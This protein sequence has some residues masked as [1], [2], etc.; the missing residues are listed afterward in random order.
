MPLQDS[1]TQGQFCWVDLLAHDQ[2]AAEKFYCDLFGWTV[3]ALDTQGGPPYGQFELQGNSV[4]GIGQMSDEMKAQGVPQMWN[5]YVNVEDVEAVT[6][7]AEQL[8]ATITMP[9]MKVLDA[10][11]LAYFMDPGGASLGLWQKENHG[12]AQVVNEPGAFCWNECA[13]RDIE[14][15]KD[16]YGSLFG[17]ETEEHKGLPSK[18]YVIKNKGRENGGLLEMTKEWGEMPSCWSVYFTVADMAT[19]VSKAKELGGNVNVEPFD[20]DVGP[21]A[22]LSDPQGGVFYLIELKAPAK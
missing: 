4:A 17:W 14:K 5:N 6:K 11:W 8:G 13:T 10:G 3:K 21:I 19:S 15:V 22:V 16:F 2:S 9:P 12:G 7:K 18:Y 20:S 1:Y